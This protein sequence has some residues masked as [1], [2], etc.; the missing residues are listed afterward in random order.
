M[1][2]GQIVH[3]VS[4]GESEIRGPVHIF[5]ERLMMRLF[6]KF[7]MGG[8]VLDAGCG[9]GS[10]SFDLLR[11]GYQV[12]AVEKSAEFVKHLRQKICSTGDVNR[13]KIQ[14]ASITQLP[15]PDKSFDGVVC[16]EVLEHVSDDVGGDKAAV[17]ELHRVTKPGSACIVSVPLNPELWDHSDEWAGH[18]KRYTYEALADLL[19]DHGFRVIEKRIWG[20]PLGRIYH[21]FLFAPWVRKTSALEAKERTTRFD[22]R[23][24]NNRTLVNL[25]ASVLR[26]DELFS[27]YPWGRGVVVAARRMD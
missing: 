25:V 15:F 1:A 24:A 8:T 5:R 18:V 11:L 27:H 3:P 17:I 16:G 19:E 14:Q 21:R 23:T 20:F 10:F 9:S 22:T 26:L 12:E 7:V 2:K 6:R 13:I 4:W